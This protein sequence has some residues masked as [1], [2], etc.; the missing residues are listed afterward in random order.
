LN[1]SLAFTRHC[2]TSRHRSRRIQSKGHRFGGLCRITPTIL[3]GLPLGP[4][5]AP[6]AVNIAS[7][8]ENNAEPVLVA[9]ASNAV[10]VLVAC[11]AAPEQAE[12]Q[13]CNVAPVAGK[14]ALGRSS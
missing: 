12:V 14:A 6:V 11:N 2:D 3:D 4:E 9:A 10:P 1:R 5:Q 13:A 7:V 8:E